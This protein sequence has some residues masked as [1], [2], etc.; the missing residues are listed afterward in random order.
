VATLPPSSDAGGWLDALSVTDAPLTRA[1]V[2]TALRFFDTRMPSLR[3]GLRFAFLKGIDLHKPVGEVLLEP[4]TTLAAFRRL[5]EEPVRLF[6]TKVGTAV[7][8]LGV[9]PAA[10]GF[11]RFRVVR[12]VSALESRAAAA[13]DT[14]TD[15][16]TVYVAAGGGVQ[17]IIPDAAGGL[18]VVA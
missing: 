10:R 3:A 12:P 1:G 2:T 6:Y 16:S 17:F 15:A 11:R 8:Q 14:W 5:N 18:E 7:S 4:K 13:R 9:N